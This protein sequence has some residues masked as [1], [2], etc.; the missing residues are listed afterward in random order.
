MSKCVVK[1]RLLDQFVQNWQTSL[2]DSSKALNCRIFKT[3]FE[4]KEYFK[5]LNI[6]DAI[7]LC[8]FRTTNQNLPIETGRWRNIDRGNR[9][10]NLCNCQKLGDEYHYVLE[11]SS[12][13]DKRKQL[14][15][16]YFMKDIML[17]NSLNFYLPKNNRCYENYVYLSNISIRSFVLL[18]Y[19][20]LFLN[21]CIFCKKSCY[22]IIMLLFFSV[23]LYLAVWE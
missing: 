22:V 23:P 10:C 13:N 6:G 1:Q 18:A 19:P 2:S 20:L 8:W 7:R 3:K 4:F 12:L 21:L 9:Y 16:K 11:C 15:P 5:I 17:S 14:L